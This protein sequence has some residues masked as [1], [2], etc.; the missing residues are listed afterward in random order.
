M[1]MFVPRP[2]AW[3]PKG[4][5][6]LSGRGLC[7]LDKLG[8]TGKIGPKLMKTRCRKR[9]RLLLPDFAGKATAIVGSL[10]MFAKVQAQ[11]AVALWINHFAEAGRDDNATAIAVDRTD[12][13][14]T[15]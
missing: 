7:L 1:P 5:R 9:S 2:A 11:P 14:S 13:K 8:K 15:R 12:R 10:L 6:R 4:V 3:M